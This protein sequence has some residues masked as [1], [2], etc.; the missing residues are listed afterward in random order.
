MITIFSTAFELYPSWKFEKTLKQE[1]LQT[2]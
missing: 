2:A 1:N